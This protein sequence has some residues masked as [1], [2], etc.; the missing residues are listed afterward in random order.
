MP[1]ITPIAYPEFNGHRF[2]RSSTDLRIDALKVR[3]WKSI[4]VDSELTPGETYGNLSTVQG[5]TRGK[6][7]FSGEI[8]LYLEDAELVEEYLRNQANPRGMGWMEYQ[9]QMIL[10]ASEP[11]RGYVQHDILGVRVTKSGLAVADSDD[12]LTVKWSLHIKNVIKNGR[13]IVIDRPGALAPA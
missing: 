12:Q 3:G 6:A 8:E 1:L 9:F 10:T 4:S 2:S 7:K 5:T 11:I 13:P